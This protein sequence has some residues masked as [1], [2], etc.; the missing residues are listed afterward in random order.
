MTPVADGDFTDSGTRRI[1]T[2]IGDLDVELSGERRDTPDAVP[3]Y[4]LRLRF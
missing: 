2:G 1:G 3:D 4:A